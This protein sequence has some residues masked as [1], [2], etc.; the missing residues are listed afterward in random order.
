MD[1]YKKYLYLLIPL[2]YLF[3]LWEMVFYGSDPIANDSIAHIPIAE[4]SK[5]VKEFPYWFPNLFSGMPSYGGYIYT[6]GD[7]TKTILNMIFLNR[8][9]KLWFYF[10]LSGIGFFILLRLLKISSISCLFGGIVSGIT[11][12]SFGLI[13]AGH[14]NKIIAMAFIP[15]ILASVIY[16]MNHKSLKSILMISVPTIFQLWSN[17]P[18]VVYYTWM[19]VVFLW[20]WNLISDLRLGEF[21]LK[22]NGKQICIIFIG[23]LISLIVVVDP[24]YHVYEF[25][26]HSNRGAKSVLDDTKET[27][28]GTDWN[29]ATQWSFHPK[30]TISFLYPYHYGLQNFPTRDM[31]SAAYWGFMPFTQSTHYLGLIVILFAILGALLRKPDRFESYMWVLS[32]LVIFVGF[33]SY[34]PALYKPLF[35]LAPFFSKFRIPSM[36]F[37]LLA[38]SIPYLAAIGLDKLITNE[39]TQ[40]VKKKIL[41]VFGGFIGLTF[42]FLIFGESILSFSSLSDNRFN[43]AIL[44]Q[45]KDFRKELF[46]KGIMLALVL[47]G[48]TFG[49]SWLFL[50][51]EV[52]KKI[53]STLIVLFSIGD[54]W[55]VNNEFLFLKK[56]EKINLYFR[57]TP[58]INYLK[59]D[60]SH[61]RIFPVD[62]LNSN[63]YGYWGIQSI[64][65]Y[66][67]VKL[68]HFQDLMDAGGFR[69]P[70][71]L[72]MLNVKY[73][74]TEKKL[75]S[76]LFS[77]V[78]NYNGLYKNRAVLPRTWFVNNIDNVTDQKTS[79]QSVLSQS[80]DPEKAAVITNYSGPEI[81]ES[82]TGTAKI[83]TLS[84]NEI[85]ITAST[86]AGG[87]LILSEI[88]YKPGWKCKIDGILT[89]IFQTN[90]VL[91]S[92]FVP[93]GT[94]SIKFFYDKSSWYITRLISRIS[95][96]II[97]FSLIFISWK[98]KGNKD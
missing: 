98:E 86:S 49:L 94:H 34:F 97:L 68:R 96:L 30:E 18:Q 55:V 7:P 81:P 40:I 14:T 61:F 83:E 65:G 92:I 20:L 82:S 6:P 9:I 27:S 77:P 4:W 29:Y 8:G 41:W 90:H 91:R 57:E 21:S 62:E 36:I 23:L 63:K 93:E 66:R 52:N 71:I 46:N 50:K 28:S 75:N 33:G 56:P 89:D 88:Y 54:L 80:F 15:W 22:N 58:L 16:G 51:G 60:N 37:I 25:Q 47:S 44:S 43:P 10:S 1:E 95:F 70:Q 3:F 59:N 84:E 39:K 19:M 38:I 76:P 73:V 72:N 17:H 2:C 32:G 67:A 13:N 69:R 24:Y 31:K 12:Y 26:K 11:P 64:G 42:I 48:S 85:V 79:L 78:I 45:V 87:L 5:S 35:L 53:F 74:L